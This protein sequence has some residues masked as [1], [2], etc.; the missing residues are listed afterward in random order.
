MLYKNLSPRGRERYSSCIPSIHIVGLE[1]RARWGRLI[2]PFK[3]SAG[4]ITMAV[5]GM[6]P[7][8]ILKAS[9][10]KYLHRSCCVRSR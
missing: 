10:H 2:T 3:A 7:S 9:E 8:N 1:T 6:L 4:T 5:V